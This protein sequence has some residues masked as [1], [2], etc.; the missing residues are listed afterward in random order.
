[1][2]I[3]NLLSENSWKIVLMNAKF[4][5]GP[6]DGLDVEVHQVL[7]GW[8]IPMMGESGRLERHAIYSLCGVEPDFCYYVYVTTEEV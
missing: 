2:S 3:L 6:M 1:M 8:F 7:P 5:G 4:I